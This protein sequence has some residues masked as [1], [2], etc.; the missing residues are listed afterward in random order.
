MAHEIYVKIIL[1]QGSATATIFFI[2]LFYLM[3]LIFYSSNHTL[4]FHLPASTI[5]KSPLIVEIKVQQSWI[6]ACDHETYFQ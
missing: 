4:T 6:E 5:C 1:F 2:G 3:L